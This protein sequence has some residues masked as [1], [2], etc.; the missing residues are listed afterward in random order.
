[1]R[2][3]L[4]LATIQDAVLEFLRGRTDAVLFGA[5]AVNAYV[6]E[7]RMTQDADILSSR[8]EGFTESVPL[9]PG[10]PDAHLDL[11]AVLDRVY[12]EAGYRYFVYDRQ[13]DP[14]LTG[15][16]A[17]WAERLVRRATGEGDDPT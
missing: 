17:A 14:P 3:P 1:M 8:A 15:D 7:P 2:E 13:P 12:D 10:D 11:R 6:D 16:D 9:R 4:P 5:Q